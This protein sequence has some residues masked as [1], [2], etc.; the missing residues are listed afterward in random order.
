MIFIASLDTIA[1][2]QPKHPSTDE[3]T[4]KGWY[5]NNGIVCGCEVEVNPDP[6]YNIKEL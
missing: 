5:T 3:W 1:K 4:N 2:R 6:S